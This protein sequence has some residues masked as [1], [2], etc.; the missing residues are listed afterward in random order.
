[1]PAPRPRHPKP[2]MACS[3]RHARATVLFSQGPVL[4]EGRPDGC[5]RTGATDRPDPLEGGDPHPPVW[6]DRGV[7]GPPPPTISI[8]RP[9][10]T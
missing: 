9:E 1:M 8:S 5:E 10:R 2:K 6:C 7:G 4:F 3:P